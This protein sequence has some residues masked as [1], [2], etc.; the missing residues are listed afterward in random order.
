MCRSA[1]RP[2]GW[3]WLEHVGALERATWR[4]Q[5]TDLPLLEAEREGATNRY[6]S[7]GPAGRLGASEFLPSVRLAG[8]FISFSTAAFPAYACD[9]TRIFWPTLNI[10]GG[11]GG[12]GWRDARYR[13]HGM[14]TLSATLSTLP[15]RPSHPGL[16][17]VVADGR[18]AGYSTQT[19]T[20]MAVL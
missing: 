13:V 19:A 18:M 20:A 12:N 9:V 8:V 5:P 4:E 3:R 14:R 15:T 11:I 1:R 6:F 10:S 7:Y 17:E 2:A 16:V